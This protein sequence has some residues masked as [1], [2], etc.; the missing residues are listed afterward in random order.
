MPSSATAPATTN[1]QD[2]QSK[3]PQPENVKKEGELHE[4]KLERMTQKC[5]PLRSRRLYVSCTKVFNPAVPQGPHNI[6]TVRVSASQSPPNRPPRKL[7]IHWQ[8][9][10]TVT[11][12]V[13]TEQVSHTRL[14]AVRR[15]VLKCPKTMTALLTAL[16]QLLCY[17]VISNGAFQ[18]I[19]QHRKAHRPFS[20]LI[21]LVKN[22][23]PQNPNGT[24]PPM[25]K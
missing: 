21:V 1:H 17:I 15:G 7:S 14:N 23:H 24:P 22:L 19:G 13:D 2:H 10:S 25:R 11:G 3:H 8:T 20:S 18:S 6:S 9:P 5:L 12:K 16:A 4:E